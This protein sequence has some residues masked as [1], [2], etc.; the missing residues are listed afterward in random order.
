MIKS[1]TGFGQAKGEKTANK[2]QAEI[3]SWNHRFFEFSLNAP[4][5]LNDFEPR[6]RELVHERIRRG[7]LVMTIS[8]STSA[9]KDECRSLDEEKIDFYLRAIR[10]IQKKYGLKGEVDVNALLA[11]PEIFVSRKREEV[12]ESVW[13]ALKPVVET[14][15]TKFLDS[16]TKEGKA[17]QQDMAKRLQLIRKSVL[18]VE[19]LAEETPEKRFQCLKDAVSKLLEGRE[20][21]RDKVEREIAVYVERSDI[22]EEIVRLRNHLDLFEKAFGETGEIGKKLDFIA[23]ELHREV[24]TIASKSQNSE[25]TAETIKMKSEIEKI[26]EQVQNVE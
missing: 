25:I 23:Q 24:N 6:L 11:I 7:K 9:K 5:F 19:K 16:K 17:L 26:R 3:R 2:W 22:T 13:N 21:S 8:Q 10:K 14:A 1:M 15:V 4:F 12:S 20:I 18:V